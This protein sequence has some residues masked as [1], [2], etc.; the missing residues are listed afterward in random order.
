MKTSVNFIMFRTS[1]IEQVKDFYKGIGLILNEEQHG[2]GPIHYSYVQDQLVIEIYPGTEA[3][4]PSWKDAGALMLGFYV[5]NINKIIQSID[6]LKGKVISNPSET[7][8]GV[9]AVIEDPDGR[10]IELIEYK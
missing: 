7:I 9:R 6:K 2:N 5:E 4:P 10:R 1:Q 3:K 8:R